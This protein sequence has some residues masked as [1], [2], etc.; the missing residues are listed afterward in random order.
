MINSESSFI[1][2]KVY[3]TYFINVKTLKTLLLPIFW[4]TLVFVSAPIGAPSIDAACCCEAIAGESSSEQCELPNHCC[5]TNC[6]LQA[7]FGITL[8]FPVPDAGL[9]SLIECA[10]F[11][12]ES[13]RLFGRRD[14]PP[15]PPPKSNWI[16]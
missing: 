15:A 2:I 8:F 6:R 5:E 3:F 16:T 13:E 14:S 7:G 10:R 11:T 1:D 9:N 4:L 12:P